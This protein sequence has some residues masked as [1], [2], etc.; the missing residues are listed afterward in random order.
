MNAGRSGDR[1][2]GS[3]AAPRTPAG[4]PSLWLARWWHRSGSDVREMESAN[5]LLSPTVLGLPGSPGSHRCTDQ[6]KGYSQSGRPNATG[7]GIATGRCEASSGNHFASFAGC[8]LAHA[9]RG[10]RTT[11][12][13]P[14]RQ[15][16]LSVPHGSTCRSARPDQCGYCSA[17]SRATNSTPTGTSSSCIRTG[18]TARASR[19][20]G[21]PPGCDMRRRH[22]SDQRRSTVLWSR[23]NRHQGFSERRGSIARRSRCDLVARSDPTVIARLR[24]SSCALAINVLI[25]TERNSSFRALRDI[26]WWCGCGVRLSPFQRLPSRERSGAQALATGLMEGWRVRNVR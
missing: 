8:S 14:S 2:A 19:I 25:N 23:A 17:M 4:L 6:L 26:A 20:P 21:I 13:S 5:A 12:S 1:S 7:S 11:N 22:A 18:V 24:F 16:A 10:S 3:T 15:I 9:I